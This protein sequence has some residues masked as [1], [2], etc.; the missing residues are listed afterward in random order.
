MH[1][2][3]IDYQ[4][5]PAYAPYQSN[6]AFDEEFIAG[7]VDKIDSISEAFCARATPIAQDAADALAQMRAAVEQILLHARQ[8]NIPI[9]AEEWLRVCFRWTLADFGY[10]F[11]RRVFSAREY[12]A[13][14]LLE[15]QAR[16]LLDMQTRGMYVTDLPKDTYDEIRRLGMEYL[17]EL[18]SRA[19]ADPSERS[20]TNVR[21]NSPLWKAIRRGVNEAGVLDVLSEFKGNQMTMLGAGLEYSYSGQRWYQNVY[22]DVGVSA[23]PFQYL[24][25]DE[26][27]CL[28]KSM[29]YVT[30]VDEKSGPTRAIPGSNCW[31][32]SECTIRMHRA[33]DRIIGDRYGN[34]GRGSYRILAR[35]A[36]LRRIF[37]ELPTALRGSSHF[38]DDILPDTD[39][40]A[41]LEKLEV[42]YLSAGGQTLVF[43]GPWLLHRGSLVNSGERLSLQ[44]IYRNRN[45]A[46]IRSILAKETFITD[47][48]ALLRK[49]AR[50]FVMAHA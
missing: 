48:V 14:V 10:E 1:F 28:P 5:H 39:L 22:S 25:Y 27:D 44:V 24:H 42:P 46:R 9:V 2:P 16:Q 41:T 35:H 15:S 45:E 33:L 19:I 49:Y 11:M 36:D 29:I 40:A 30:P 32:A 34:L 31:E 18:K 3:N 37:M 20:V 17:G 6:V 12:R 4:T 43:D 8:Q 7:Q 26:G 47:Q 13:K 38:G 50:N 23:G 21:F